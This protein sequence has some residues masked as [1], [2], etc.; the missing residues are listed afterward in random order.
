MTTLEN[1]TNSRRVRRRRYANLRRAAAA[2]SVLGLASCSQSTKQLRLRDETDFARQHDPATAPRSKGHWV[3]VGD[4]RAYLAIP[5]NVRP[6][7]PGVLVLHTARG[8]TRDIQLWTD[9]LSEEGYGALAVDFYHGRS[10]D[11]LEE[12]KAL[13]DEANKHP[14]ENHAMLRRAFDL[15]ATDPRIQAR[16]RALVGWSYGAAWGTHLASQWSDVDAVVAYYGAADPAPQNVAKIGAQVLLICGAQDGEAE[17]VV[18]FE[19]SLRSA[20]KTF[21]VL[22]NDEGHN[23]ADP[24]NPR[25]ASRAADTAYREVRHFLDLTLRE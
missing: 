15:L 23:F 6:P 10:S 1:A 21:R 16:R 12:A 19:A 3:T 18:A 8:L 5:P 20:G 24:S 4:S 13:R 17:D 9:R 11:N 2:L 22:W 25:Y 7:M 14:D